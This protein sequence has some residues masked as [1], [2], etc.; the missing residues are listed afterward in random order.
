[1]GLNLGNTGVA[2][3][4]SSSCYLQNKGDVCVLACMFECPVQAATSFDPQGTETPSHQQ[5][6]DPNFE[7]YTPPLRSRGP[8]NGVT[9][10]LQPK[11]YIS[12]KMS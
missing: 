5:I 3:T 1:M 10:S 9:G 7:L 4:I 12:A 8:K 6:A 2:A 11:H